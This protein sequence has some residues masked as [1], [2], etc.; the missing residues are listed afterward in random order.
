MKT[1]P[2]PAVLAAALFAPA[3]F[4]SGM[5][6]PASELPQTVTRSGHQF[7]AHCSNDDFASARF[8][9]KLARRCALLLKTWQAEASGRD[10]ATPIVAGIDRSA[11]APRGIPA[12]P[13]VTRGR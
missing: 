10:N 4:A 13:P 7:I 1:L 2:F 8:P 5:A 9:E 12:Q 6:T 3:A 11:N